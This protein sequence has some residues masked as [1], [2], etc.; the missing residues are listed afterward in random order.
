MKDSNWWLAWAIAVIGT[1]C[2][3]VWVRA[4]LALISC[5]IV[6]VG[7]MKEGERSINGK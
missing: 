6:V 5:V 3:S 7:R 2:E 4:A 1:S